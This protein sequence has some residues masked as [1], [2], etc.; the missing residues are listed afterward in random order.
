MDKSFVTLE[1]NRCMVC[2]K[3]FDTGAL[4]IDRRLREK[5]DR[6]TLTGTGLCPEHQEK[7]DEGYVAMVAVDPAKSGA[8]SGSPTLKA[9]DAYR[10]GAVAH[11][12]FDAWGKIFN[13]PPPEKDGERLPMVFVDEQVITMLAE[14]LGG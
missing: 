2:G 12:K 5:F 11:V 8:F 3:D 10:T 9:E 7:Y 4:L 6:F 14:K 13:S 1:Q